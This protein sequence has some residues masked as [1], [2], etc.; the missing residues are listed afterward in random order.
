MQP[1]EAVPLRQVPA[2]LA[3]GAQ[4]LAGGLELCARGTP[5]D[6][7]HAMPIW[8]PGAREAQKGAVPLHAGVQ[9]TQPSQVGVLWGH[10]EA[11][12]LSPLRKH[13]GA[14]LRVVLRAKGAAPSVGVAAPQGLTPTAGLDD[15]VTPEVQGLVQRH[16][17]QDG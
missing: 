11:Q 1:L 3:P 15:F 2:L 13:P 9:T 6:A 17:G 16:M 12:F 4:P 14:P 5:H 10:L 8:H 7:G